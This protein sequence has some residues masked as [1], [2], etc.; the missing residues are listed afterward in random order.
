MKLHQSHP[1]FWIIFT[2]TWIFHVWMGL[3]Q[4]LMGDEAF[5]AAATNYVYQVIPRPCW[6]WANLI[7]GV[8]LVLSSYRRF[9]H[10]TRVF[11]AVGMSLATARF[12]MI[13]WGRFFDGLQAGISLPLWF[14]VAALHLAQ[15]MEPPINP[16]TWRKKGS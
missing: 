9:T 14:L 7:V 6:G 2:A 13:V 15:T 5:T 11:L 3:E 4:L 1:N 16:A 10:W 12:L 8:G